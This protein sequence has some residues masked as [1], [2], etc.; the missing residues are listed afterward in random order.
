MAKGVDG[1]TKEDIIYKYELIMNNIIQR[2]IKKGCWAMQIFKRSCDIAV[3]C[4][5]SSNVS[6][7][8][9]VGKWLLQLNKTSFEPS[10]L[11]SVKGEREKMSC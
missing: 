7:T 4:C 11:N 5:T 1:S 10:T 3:W 2:I 8:S 9:Y 6:L